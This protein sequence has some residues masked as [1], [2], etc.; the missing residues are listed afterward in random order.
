M[1]EKIWSKHYTIEMSKNRY[2]K[3]VAEV[4]FFGGMGDSIEEDRIIYAAKENAKR[5]IRN[6]LKAGRSAPLART[7]YEV[8]DTVVDH[9]DCTWS[10]VMGEK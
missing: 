9:K 2:G 7:Y 8:I 6:G 1:P 3:T 5:Y 10:I 4:L